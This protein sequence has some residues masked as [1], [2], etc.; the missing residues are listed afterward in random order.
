[1]AYKWLL[2]LDE[3][4]PQL[5]KRARELNKRDDFIMKYDPKEVEKRER[6]EKA[7]K[8]RKKEAKEKSQFTP[9]AKRSKLET[10]HVVSP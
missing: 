2:K 8:Q 6:D 3:K 10:E 4:Y 1:M 9:N 7:R 5:A